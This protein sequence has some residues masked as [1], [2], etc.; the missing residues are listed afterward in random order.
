[1]MKSTV[2][3]QLAGLPLSDP[4]QHL[5]QPLKTGVWPK[6]CGR[7]DPSRKKMV[8]YYDVCNQCNQQKW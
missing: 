4:D 1:M 2:S 6:K 3:P 8:N 7:L 5:A